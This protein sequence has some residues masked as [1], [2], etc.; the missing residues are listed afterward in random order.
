MGNT[1]YIH[2]K[3]SPVAETSVVIH[4][5]Y[6]FL[7][8]YKNLVHTTKSPNFVEIPYNNV[9][10]EGNVCARFSFVAAR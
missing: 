8:A 7:L 2:T 1:Q 4:I 3:Y 9:N 6:F 10:H 5:V